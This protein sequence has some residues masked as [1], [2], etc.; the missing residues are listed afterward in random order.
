MSDAES[1]VLD[2]FPDAYEASAGSDPQLPAGPVWLVDDDDVR[3]SLS[4]ALQPRFDTRT[5]P[6]LEAF[7]TKADLDRPGCLVIADRFG[8]LGTQGG[9]G[10]AAAFG[11]SG[12]GFAQA[13]V[14][15]Q[16]ELK[17]RRSP[18]A[19][20]FLASQGDVRSA[21]RA[22]RSGA[23]SFLE[24]PVDPEELA[25]A[26]AEGLERSRRAARRNTL[27]EL[28]ESLSK[29]ERQI[30]VL[31]CHGLKNGDIAKL[32]NLSQRTVEVHRAHIGRKLGN[33]APIRLLYELI[34]AEGESLFSAELEG[35]DPEALA[36]ALKASG[37]L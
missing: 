15:V 7:L 33:A 24:K 12:F 22:M 26:V 34:L 6:S 4:F 19:V 18:I 3:E 10:S 14:S 5:F 16:H 35:V 17:L 36:L 32:L 25:E 11:A 20:V 31:I 9:F 27:A 37:G 13:E 29:R 8:G 1:D 21:V 28:F 23:V 2:A 30:F